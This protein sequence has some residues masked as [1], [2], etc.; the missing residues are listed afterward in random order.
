LWKC[1][2][3][4]SC[5]IAAYKVVPWLA[6]DVNNNAVLDEWAVYIAQNLADLNGYT[7]LDADAKEQFDI[8]H[9]RT[10]RSGS[11]PHSVAHALRML[12]MP[13]SS[14][15]AERAFSSYNKLV[16]STM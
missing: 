4:A 14:A 7:N 6:K 1:D 2:S 11:L 12:N 13:V 8:L 15:D 5:D 9:Y 3:G 16:S 10:D